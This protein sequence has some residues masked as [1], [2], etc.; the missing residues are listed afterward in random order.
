MKKLFDE[1][2]YEVSKCTTRKYSTSFSLGILALK[3]SIRSAIYAIYGYVRLAD[4]IV[5]S[6]HDYDKEKLLSKLKK[7]TYNAIEEGISLNPI[8]QAF[9][10]TVHDYRIDREL[11]D[12]FLHSM[13]MDL[14]KIDFDSKLY[15]EYIYGS[16]EVVG[17]MCL[18]VFT[19]GNKEKFE[20]LK[21]YA[22]KLGSAFQKINFLRDLKDDYQI[23]GRT[24]FPDINMSVFD[25]SVK[26]KIEDEIE[27]EFKQA[28]IG[29]KKLPGSSMFGVYLAYRYYLSLFYK[30]KKTSSQRIMQNRIRIANSQK[31]LLACESY[32]RYKVAYL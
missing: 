19:E 7:E 1:L 25:N 9:Q 14:Q 6:F 13:E 4:E 18:Q 16:A 3:P 15:N 21:P 11:I 22:M 10:Q 26:F 17:L 30:I 28:L 29:I 12:T 8:L 32:I 23:L 31:L 24:Y 5:D 20:E 27:T 2:S